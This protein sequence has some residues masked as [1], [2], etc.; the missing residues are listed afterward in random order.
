MPVIHHRQ[1]RG[2]IGFQHGSYINW[3]Q[4]QLICMCDWASEAVISEPFRF[5]TII[6][7]YCLY[8][9][10]SIIWDIYIN[11]NINIYIHIKD[12]YAYIH[13]YMHIY[14]NREREGDIRVYI[15]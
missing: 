2:P 7:I 11:M 3:E 12:L 8:I 4:L 5:D 14:I 10:I 6:Y 1:S 9:T 15:Y 13:Q